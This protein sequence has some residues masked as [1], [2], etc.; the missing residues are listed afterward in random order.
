MTDTL[1][2][3][4][5]YQQLYG[6][7]TLLY[8][9]LDPLS[10]LFVYVEQLPG[11]VTCVATGANAKW[12]RR[13]RRGGI[14]RYL[15]VSKQLMRQC[16]SHTLLLMCKCGH[17]VSQFLC[18]PAFSRPRAVQLHANIARSNKNLGFGNMGFFNRTFGRKDVEKSQTSE[19]PA[20][21][22]GAAPA[23]ELSSG[24]SFSIPSV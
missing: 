15:Q 21:E 24:A 5:F 23:P 7:L 20:L 12:H 4:D 19:S 14:S 2:H 8:F 13:T 10:V 16:H 9:L 11:L 18:V 1:A 6:M 17:G 3:L 22:S